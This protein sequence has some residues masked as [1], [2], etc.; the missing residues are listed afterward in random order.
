M[1]CD[2]PVLATN[3]SAMPEVAG[4]AALLIPAGDDEALT[5]GMERML[6]DQALGAQLR[7]RGRPRIER[8]RPAPVV[9]QLLEVLTAA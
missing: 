1:A 8:F 5:A 3:V 9:R 2:C 7:Q 6:K 4:D